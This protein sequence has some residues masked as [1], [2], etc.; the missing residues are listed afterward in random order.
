MDL[1]R[2]LIAYLE[3]MVTERRRMLFDRVSSYRTRYVTV[4]V[5]DPAEPTD[6]S[7]V[8]RSCECFGIQDMHIIAQSRPFNVHVG[9]AV[10][11]SKWIDAAVHGR[12]DGAPEATIRLMDDLAV[13]G[14]LR[15]A[16]G[17]EETSTPIE[18]VPLERPVAI[19][20]TTGDWSPE[21]LERVDTHAHIPTAGF[22]SGFNISVTASLVLSSITERLQASEID[23]RLS[24]QERTDLRL[25][26]LTKMSK[27]IHD[28]LERF[29]TDK[30]L[31][32][33]ALHEIDVPA[34]RA[35]LRKG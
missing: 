23:W 20:L 1:E 14:Y 9:V 17:T 15:V 33:D 6:A 29:C 7:A 32:P 18:A 2:E 8:M 21:L 30:G 25:T 35:L 34:F 26:W 10:G 22:T 28:Q 4:V 3:T 31:D 13:R 27:R 16:I 12:G 19:C 5:E 11:S 24:E